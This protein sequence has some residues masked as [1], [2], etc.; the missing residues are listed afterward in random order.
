VEEARELGLRATEE[1]GGSPSSRTRRNEE[2][3]TLSGVGIFLV[4]DDFGCQ[5][6]NWVSNLGKNSTQFK[7]KPVT[8]V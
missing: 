8:L 4:F 2:I 1:S 3:S 7:G 6:S 5:V